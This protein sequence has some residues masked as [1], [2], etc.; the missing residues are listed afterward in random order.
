MKG[1]KRLLFITG[2]IPG[3]FG[4]S[5]LRAWNVL[6]ALHSCYEIDLLIVPT[7][8]ATSQPLSEEVKSLCSRIFVFSY[9]RRQYL[10]REIVRRILLFLSLK[11]HKVWSASSLC[12]IPTSKS[13]IKPIISESPS[14][15]YKVIHLYKLEVGGLVQQLKKHYQRAAMQLDLDDFES[16]TWK[17]VKE[18]CRLNG[19]QAKAGSLPCVKR[20]IDKWKNNYC[21]SLIGYTS[22]R[23]SISIKLKGPI[24]SITSTACPIFLPG[25]RQGTPGKSHEPAGDYRYI[26]V[27]SWGYYPNLD[28]LLYF[29]RDILPLLREKHARPFVVQ[30]IGKGKLPAEVLQRLNTEKEIDFIGEVDRVDRYYQQADAALVP[31]RAGGGTRLKVLEAFAFGVPVIATAVGVEGLEI[32]H[33]KHA[34]IADTPADFAALCVRLSQDPNLGHNLAQHAAALLEEK[35]SPDRLKEILCGSATI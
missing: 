13:I 30:V 4:G 28:S 10:F 19:D 15:E 16:L 22:A 21:R 1:E 34:L 2:R 32:D 26:W 9:N 8:L 29:C 20:P 14:P 5:N 23:T 11:T 17:R 33:G 27:G 6:V 35:Y 25:K 18:I 31:L 12:F 7:P 24:S 3:P